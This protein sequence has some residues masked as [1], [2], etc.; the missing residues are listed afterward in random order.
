MTEHAHPAHYRYARGPA[1]HGHHRVTFVELFFDLVFVFAITQL[2]HGLIH[3]PTWLGLYETT[4]LTMAVWWVWIYTSWATNWADPD[5]TPVRLALFALMAG[6]L[7]MS[8]AIPKAFEG[9]AMA[10]ALAYAGMQ[11]L[12]SLAM[13]GVMAEYSPGHMRNFQRLTVWMLP[14]AALLV[15]GAWLGGTAQIV[16]W[17]LAVAVD[18]LGPALRYWLPGLG[19]SSVEHWNIEPAH[20]AERCGLFVIIA[21]GESILVTGATFADLAWTW[22]T[23]VAFLA[24]FA[25]SAAMWWIYF[26]IGQERGVAAMSKS[27]NVGLVGRA[28]TYVHLFIV[29]GIILT[30]VADEFVLKHATGHAD[31]KTVAALIG[32]AALY[33]AGCA[34]FKRATAGWYPLSHSAGLLVLAVLAY[35]G[36]AAEPWL[37]SVLVS[38]VLIAIA[39]WERLSLGPDAVSKIGHPR[40]RTQAQAGAGPQGPNTA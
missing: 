30:A 32:G 22:Q 3:H 11:V 5:K 2:S 14:P 23:W 4:L 31:G 40:E 16:L 34:L 29:G 28:Y 6:G 21:L 37:L 33:V 26:N 1:T 12:R 20:F 39:V 10:F 13:I 7:V 17:T 18:Y 19:H 9:R 25:G 15:A 24:S 38:L 27:A 35:A 36:G 8:M